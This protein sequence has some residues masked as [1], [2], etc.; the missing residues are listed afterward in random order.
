MR[1][2]FKYTFASLLALLI[3]LGVSIG[4]LLI[5]VISIASLSSKDSG[6]EV[7]DKSVLVFNLALNINDAKRSSS[8][9]EALQEAISDGDGGDSITLRETLDAIDQAT[10]DKR[11]VGMYLYGNVEG[12]QAAPATPT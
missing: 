2:F 12:V 9:S 1:D 10:Q 4:G 7:K 8:P 11:I 5:L 6:P 3:F